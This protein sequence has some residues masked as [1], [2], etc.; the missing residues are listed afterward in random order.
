MCVI[1]VV[2]VVVVVVVFIIKTRSVDA[3]CVLTFFMSMQ[4]VL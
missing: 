2:V 4:L 3:A 1:V